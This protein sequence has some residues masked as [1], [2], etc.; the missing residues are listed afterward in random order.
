MQGILRRRP[1]DGDLVLAPS[2][3]GRSVTFSGRCVWDDGR[4]ARSLRLLVW[5]AWLIS[6]VSVACALAVAVSSSHSSAWIVPNVAPLL[7]C[8]F[9]GL[10]LCLRVPTN[11]IGWLFLI[12]ALLLGVGKLC[13]AYSGVSPMLFGG[14]EAAF[15]AALFEP[16]VLFVLPALLLLF[17]EGRLPS[18]RW[19]PVG[20]LWA[21]AVLALIIGQLVTPDNGTLDSGRAWRNPFEVTGIVGAVASYVAFLGLLTVFPLMI[22]GAVSLITRYRRATGLLRQQLKWFGTA[23]TVLA[24]A[25][26]GLPLSW[27]S[28]SWTTWYS[29]LLSAAGT[30]LAV[31]TG[32]AILR[33]RLYEIDVIIRKTLIYA[34][35]AAML[36]TL[37]LGGIWATTWVFRSITGQSGALA[38]TLST[39]A[40]AAAFQPLRTRIQRS[41]DHR[42]YRQKYDAARTLDSFSAHLR[43][44]IDL[45]ALHT[46]VLDV[47]HVT[48]QPSHASIWLRPSI[49]EPSTPKPIDPMP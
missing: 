36:A 38:V 24:I 2:Q 43:D 27:A 5:S 42:F 21:I 49:H 39:L 37:Y 47:V 3:D 12:T 46:D 18:R 9:V 26:V 28:P 10:V 15:A 11:A 33:Y 35:L 14:R 1:D 30:G 8:A 45:A 16:L 32:V 34:G 6:V 17:P 40:V 13:D 22:A 29:A 44:Q 20:W 31:A 25:V 48:L 23:A 4:V 19:R 41:V 7:G